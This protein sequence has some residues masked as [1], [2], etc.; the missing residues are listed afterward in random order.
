MGGVFTAPGLG[1]LP[2]GTRLRGQLIEEIRPKTIHEM[3]KEEFAAWL[4]DISGSCPDIEEPLDLPP[5]PLDDPW[6]EE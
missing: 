6:D 4:D 5:E 3:T 1:S 2:D